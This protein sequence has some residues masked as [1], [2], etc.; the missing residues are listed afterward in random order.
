MG[1][2]V[3]ATR[4]RIAGAE[5]GVGRKHKHNWRNH[6][7]SN[8]KQLI[9]NQIIKITQAQQYR[10]HP[11]TKAAWPQYRA[12][13]AAR[14]S[15]SCGVRRSRSRS[16]AA[17]HARLA[18]TRE[19]AAAT[20]PRG[21]RGMEIVRKGCLGKPYL[22][23][24]TFFG[25]DIGFLGPVRTHSPTPLHLLAARTSHKQMYWKK[26]NQ[27]TNEPMTSFASP[28]TAPWMLPGDLAV[29]RAEKSGRG[30]QT[31]KSTRNRDNFR[32]TG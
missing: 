5:T 3:G 31:N 1:V 18:T 30:K 23:R 28:A 22:Q 8:H 15:A 7:G 32:T 2:T 20:A 11:Q 25:N 9:Q 19:A 6:T 16:S 14:W 24:K 17:V 10:G 12:Q 26:H 13:R 21:R 29:D 27:P 4:R